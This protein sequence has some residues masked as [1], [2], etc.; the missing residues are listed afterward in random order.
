[1]LEATEASPERFRI[2]GHE[3]A[4]LYRFAAQSGLR[5][6]EIRCLTIASFDFDNQL[7]TLAGKYTKN[8]Q[9]TTLP[10]RKDTV[11]MLKELFVN[12]LPHIAAFK[13]PSKY[14]MADMLRADLAAAQIE[15][16]P[17][18]GQVCFHSLRHSF[19]SML[20]A[21]GC[22]PKVA[23]ELLRHSDI[24]LSLSRYSH[25]LTGQT[26]KAV[27]ALPD[28]SSEAHKATGTND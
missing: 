5:A 10:L 11:A 3:R 9:D 28:L 27:E 26:A 25:V 4:L 14:N 16:D 21:S 2:P 7:V 8:G 6:N 17:E 23:Q 24:N 20:A 18:R 15:I 12:K 19:G 22:H 13:L 1:L